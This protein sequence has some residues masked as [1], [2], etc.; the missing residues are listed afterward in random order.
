MSKVWR[1]HWF[2]FQITDDF[3]DVK[4]KNLKL[5]NRQKRQEKKENPL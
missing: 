3:L 4:G 1:G 5:E 2:L